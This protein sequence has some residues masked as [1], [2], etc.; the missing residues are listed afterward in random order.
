ML[1]TITEL[2]TNRHHLILL[3]IISQLDF[4]IFLDLNIS[5]ITIFPQ[6]CSG[7]IFLPSLKKIN[8]LDFSIFFGLKYWPINNFSPIL[9]GFCLPTFTKKNGIQ[10]GQSSVTN[11]IKLSQNILVMDLMTCQ[12]K[13]EF[14]RRKQFVRDF[15]F[16]HKLVRN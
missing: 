16:R 2:L 10:R 4:S 9:S 11:M 3:T 6:F 8:Q 13:Y 7:F 14:Q 1:V 15:K 12:Y 5:I